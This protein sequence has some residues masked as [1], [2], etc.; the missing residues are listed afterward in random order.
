MYRIIQSLNRYKLTQNYIYTA[1]RDNRP[2][3]RLTAGPNNCSVNTE[4]FIKTTMH[5]SACMLTS[6]T[7]L[8][9]VAL[10]HAHT[11]HHPS[12]LLYRH[13]PE[14]PSL[15]TPST[16]MAYRRR[17]QSSLSIW[18]SICTSTSTTFAS[19]SSDSSRRIIADGVIAMELTCPPSVFIFRLEKE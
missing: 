10:K 16:V 7:Q 19:K 17:Y 9:Q 13:C 14:L 12:S 1:D 11:S 3:F 18:S 8:K 6:L 2:H 5:W 15:A 4:K